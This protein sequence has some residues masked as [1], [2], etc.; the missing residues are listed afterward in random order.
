MSQDS[1]ERELI[2]LPL[3]G[4]DEDWKDWAEKLTAIL[5]PTVFRFDFTS[6]VPSGSI[7]GWG[8]TAADIP[9][10]WELYSAE[11][12]ATFIYIKKL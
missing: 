3:P 12:P 6:L 8:G 4:M 7:V 5:Q 9:P 2:D 10:G 11:T 1:G